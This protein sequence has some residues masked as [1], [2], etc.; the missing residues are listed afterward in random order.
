MNLIDRYL[1]AIVVEEKELQLLG[2]AALL[3]A[4]KY[5]EIYPPSVNELIKI[6]DNLFTRKMLLTKEFQILQCI[7]FEVQQTSPYRFLQRY[8]KIA[9]LNDDTFFL[10]QYL[11]EL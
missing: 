11:I 10:A 8:S 6:T 3:I 9:G 4:T 5:E 2:V 1:S 7:Q